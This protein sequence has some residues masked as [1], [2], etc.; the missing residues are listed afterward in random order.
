MFVQFLRR[1]AGVSCRWAVPWQCRRLS[2]AITLRPYQQQCIDDCVDA[3]A[4]G[5][6]RIGV[7]L[8]TGS[9]KTTV[10]ISLLNR[11]PQI[12]KHGKRALVIVN[13][14]ELAR[15]SAE[16]VVRLF[17]HWSVEI[18][19]GGK[20]I[21]S[22]R[23]DVTIATYQTL[24]QPERIKKFKPAALK[25][26]IID[27]AHHAAALSYRR[28]LSHFDAS[29]P[30]PEALPTAADPGHKIPIVGFSATFSR[31]DGLKLGA[32][33]DRI[34]YHQDFLTMIQ[35]QWLCPV[36]FTTTRADMNLNAVTVNSRSGD[37]NA[38][39][40]AHVVNTEMV[41]TL[42][43]QTWL[44]KAA[45]RKSTLVFCVNVAHVHL[46]TQAFR[47]FGIDARYIYAKTPAP[48]RK[49]LI[50]AFK[51]GKFPILVNCAI[52]TEGADIPNIDC[53]MVVRPTRSR[54]LFAQMIGR[55]MRLSPETGKEDCRI[56]D[57]VDSNTRVAGVISTPSLFG[58]NPNEIDI[59]DDSLESLWRRS[60]DRNPSFC[61]AA[62]DVPEPERVT[63]IDY[64]DPLSFLKLSDTP[65]IK[66]LSRNA[67]IAIGEEKFILE[68]LGKGHIKVELVKD[69]AENEPYWK[70]MFTPAGLDKTTAYQLKINP[71][72]R[73]RKV[74]QAPSLDE[75]IKASDTY[76]KTKAVRGPMVK[77][78]LRNAQWRKAPATDSQK[79]IVAKRY[80]LSV[81]D[82]C[83]PNAT[84]P[85]ALQISRMTK[86]EAAD[87]IARLK[88]GALALHAKRI[89]EAQKAQKNYDKEVQRR[90]RETV[91]IGQLVGR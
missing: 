13:S 6:S 41:N 39:S 24:I 81:E 55:G 9:G 69:D 75:A 22:G 15:Q 82:V 3:V 20:H 91:T 12:N 90:S 88:H 44:E 25:A 4:T 64:N 70:A 67:W 87:T 73:A 14:V 68:C 52:L 42:V 26:I 2:T 57:F 85:M 60:G 86:G 18:E 27:E 78:L 5:A 31:H 36:R 23:A 16:Q 46:L 37:F 19:Q 43:V 51:A 29:I 10:F 21:A 32:V 62:E 54:N 79:A 56:I 49:A 80:R 61:Y 84:D 77:G 53:V 33:F 71:F 76:A 11:L 34:V 58:L 30:H 1:Q 74:C 66:T 48:E 8:P 40:L 59:N 50:A 45:T 72:M 28:I 89:K 38:T 35:D 7:S 65:H 83:D 47:Q 63:Y 17:P